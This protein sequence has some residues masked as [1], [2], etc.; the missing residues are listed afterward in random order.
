P[1]SSTRTSD[2]IAA[3]RRAAK[4]AVAE[5]SAPAIPQKDATAKAPGKPGRK[6]ALFIGLMAILLIVGVMR[7]SAV[8]MPLFFHAGPPAPP[9]ASP[10]A[11][12]EPMEKQSIIPADQDPVIASAP[13]SGVL[14]P[15]PAASL[16][17][18]PETD[19]EP[20]GSVKNAKPARPLVESAVAPARAPVELPGSIGTA[21]LRTA[22]M[23]ADPTAAYEI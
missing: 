10:Q 1:E 3:A 17:A 23:A 11:E 20:T 4:A 15:A 2:F 19:P 12:P 14:S 16:L 18:K 9:A 6:Q 21:A 7:F 8:W 5:Q 22:A 13:P